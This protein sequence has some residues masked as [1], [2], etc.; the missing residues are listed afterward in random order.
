MRHLRHDL[1]LSLLLILGLFFFSHGISIA[2]ESL[3]NIIEVS[4]AENENES[5]P[6]ID[7]VLK[8]F[9]DDEPADVE[10]DH[11]GE[12]LSAASLD[13]HV[14]LGAT[15]NF[16]H[17]SPEKGKTDWYGLSRF[18]PEARIDL[19]TK[20]TPDWRILIG[21]KLF[22]DFAYTLKGRDEFTDEVL[23]AYE[24]EAELAEAFVQGRLSRYFDV[25]AGRQIVVW[26]RSDNIRITD[27]LNPLDLREPG[28]T[29]I[30]DLRLP[31]T[32][33]RLDGYW[34]AW[35][36]STIALHEI[37]FGKSPAFGHDF[38]PGQARL[39]EE[40]KP[41]CGGSD[42]EWALALSGTF[43]GKDIS[44]YWADLFNDVAHVERDRFGQLT[45]EHARVT[46]WGAAGN[47]AL[48]N[49][50]LKGEAAYWQDLQF[51][52]VTG[53]RFERLDGLLGI[54][55]TG[56]NE[57]TVSVDWAV[58]HI[59]S[60]DRRLTSAP[61]YAQE[62]EFQ[63]ALRITRDYLNETLNVTLL[64]MVYGS[65]GQDGALE[66]L[67]LSYDWNDA[68]S[69]TLGMVLYQSGDSFLL[70]DI[71][72]NDRIFLEIKYSF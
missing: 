32:M 4:E 57:T 69:T 51:F 33:T 42:T 64:A 6:Q 38:F 14:K 72:D 15:W 27:V 5:D 43:S 21:T 59:Q 66:R 34:A 10:M 55:Y 31:V 61:D 12:S 25:K 67:T 53:Q 60:F 71:D 52:N 45:R 18:R 13:G 23:D 63:S 20:V 40:N 36:L 65:L 26:G 1:A 7:N 70:S 16:A 30:E 3:D 37:R 8:G 29:D 58:R 9:D 28:L 46:L 56:W 39:P 62:D 35:N 49:W 44:F 48:G 11:G 2:E 50:L 41:G 68:V 47:L 17:D 22:Y 24:D 19:E 54:E